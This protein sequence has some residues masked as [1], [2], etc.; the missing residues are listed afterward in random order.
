ML[1]GFDPKYGLFA[2]VEGP[3]GGTLYPS[4]LAH[5]VDGGLAA[6]HHMGVVLGKALYEGILV[7]MALAP[8]FITRLQVPMMHRCCCACACAVLLCIDTLSCVY[9]LL[10][11]VSI[12]R[13]A[14]KHT[15]EE[16]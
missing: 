14:A 5:A 4:A 9:V 7:D 12:D 11:V 2:T 8:F 1:Q 3:S 16:W 15:V 6:V 10:Y 13:K